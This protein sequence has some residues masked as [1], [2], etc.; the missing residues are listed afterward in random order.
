MKK[1]FEFLLDSIAA[2]LLGVV[3]TFAFAPYEIFPLAVVA[4]AGLLGLWI[5]TSY[6]LQRTLWLGFF[7]G[8]GLFGAGVYWIFTS[9]HLFGGVPTILAVFITIGMIAALAAFPASVGYLLNRFFPANNTQ[10]MIYAFPAIW[11]LTEWLRGWLFTGFPWLFLGYSQTNSPLKGYAPIMGVY[12][13]SLA[14]IVSSALVV[15]TIIKYKQKDFRSTYLNLLTLSIIWILGG[16]FSLIPWTRPQGEPISVALVQGNIPQ[17]IKW[18]PEHVQLSYDRY[19]KLTEPLWGKNKLIIWPEAAIPVPL[20][21]TESFINAMD[22]KSKASGSTLM[23]G[24]PIRTPDEKGYYNTIVALGEKKNKVYLKRHLVPFGEYTPL[25][26]FFSSTL[27][28]LDIPMSEM[29]SGKMNQSPLTANNIKIQPSI[30]YE[31]AFPDLTRFTDKSIN[32]LLVVTNDAWFGDS[33]AEPQHLQMAA[34][35]ALELGRP[36]LF[37]SNDGITAIIGPNGKIEAAAPQRQATV[38]STTVQPMYGITPWMQNGF[39][40]ILLILIC[41]LFM[42]NQSKKY[43]NERVTDGRTI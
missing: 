43:L 40:P 10:K 16:L 1:S 39:D 20:Q 29:I 5:K 41:L 33:N 19:V 6:S 14:T 17:A 30:C 27:K 37:A 32:M 22:E 2:I 31:I 26:E 11:V 8:L 25:T 35:R 12:L 38:L 4:P 9:I 23:L 34:M 36:V 21:S 7:F 3:L 28:F 13:V 24:I 42:A 15:N 18:S